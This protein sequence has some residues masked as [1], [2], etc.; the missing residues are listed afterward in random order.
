MLSAHFGQES[1]RTKSTRRIKTGTTTVRYRVTFSLWK[2]VDGSSSFIADFGPNTRTANRFPSVHNLVQENVCE[3]RHHAKAKTSHRTAHQ[4][5]DHRTRDDVNFPHPERNVHLDI[6]PIFK[7]A[8][9]MP[10][11]NSRCHAL[12]RSVQAP[13]ELAT[14]PRPSPAS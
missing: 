10:V 6:S 1:T 8:S 9:L 5:W 12:A 7:S 3:N 13:L 4:F 14:L 2:V 11:S